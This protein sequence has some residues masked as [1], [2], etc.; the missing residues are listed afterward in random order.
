MSRPLP[1]GI[2]RG[3]RFEDWSPG[4]PAYVVADVDGT[5][6]GDV[7]EVTGPVLAALTA[8]HEAGL[9]LGFAT[10]R[11]R[12]A[13][14]PL[15]RQTRLG[16]PHIVHNGAEVRAEGRTIASWPLTPAQATTVQR[17]CAEH[18]WYA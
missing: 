7:P 15:W 18:G 6:L 9:A 14:A 4:V 17:L 3:G 2:R 5:L 13:V 16:G 10:G 1:D 8:A 12:A 11:M